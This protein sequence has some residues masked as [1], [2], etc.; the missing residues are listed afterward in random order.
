MR[1]QY[2]HSEGATACVLRED[3][4]PDVI[5]ASILNCNEV[6]LGYPRIPVILKDTECLVVIL[7]PSESVFVND[8]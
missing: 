8:V 6:V 1:A 5:K 3:D 4:V 7:E 2:V